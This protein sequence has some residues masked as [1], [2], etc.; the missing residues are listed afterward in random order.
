VTARFSAP[1]RA[2]YL[3]DSKNLRAT[4]DA[5]LAVLGRRTFEVAEKNIRYPRDLALV[6]LSP[7][8]VRISV[9]QAPKDI[10]T[11]SDR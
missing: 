8:T 5:S 6:D 2:F 11:E 3:F 7:T 1:R 9:V 10:A 4:V